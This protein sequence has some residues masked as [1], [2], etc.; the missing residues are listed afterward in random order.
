MNHARRLITSFA[1]AV[2][3][4]A[5]TATFA[6]APPAAADPICGAPGTPPCAGPSPLSPDQQCALIA[7]RTM[8]PCNWL[9]VKVPAGTPGS[10]DN[11]P[12]PPPPAPQP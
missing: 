3:A 8:M 6:T 4:T 2:A 10:W 7:W 9:G 5:A 12:A 11:P 1:A